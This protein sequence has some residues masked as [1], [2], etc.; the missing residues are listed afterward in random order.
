MPNLNPPLSA[1][2][3]WKTFADRRGRSH[4][5]C[6]T[7]DLAWPWICQP[8]GYKVDSYGRQFGAACESELDL[9]SCVAPEAVSEQS[10]SELLRSVAATCVCKVRADR[11]L[12]IAARLDSGP[13][14]VLTADEAARL[15][16]QL[17]AAVMMRNVLSR[18]TETV[19]NP[20][21]R[22]EINTALAAWDAA[23]KPGS[24]LDGYQERAADKGE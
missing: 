11:L 5:L 3:A 9:I 6:P 19:I 12:E 4:Q 8:G 10:D 16:R 17:A 20:Y 21:W 18:I 2:D 1:A 7:G 22:G 24:L 23:D 13:Q 14:R 15:K